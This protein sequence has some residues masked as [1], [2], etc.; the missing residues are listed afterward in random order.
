MWVLG[1]ELK[2][3]PSV[4]IWTNQKPNSHDSRLSRDVFYM[5]VSVLLVSHT[6]VRHRI[7]R[8]TF[9]ELFSTVCLRKFEG[10]TKFIG[11]FENCDF[12]AKKW[13]LGVRHQ[14]ETRVES[15]LAKPTH[16][17][18]NSIG[19]SIVSN[20]NR[21][22]T[23]SSRL[24]HMPP[25]RIWN[26]ELDRWFAAPTMCSPTSKTFVTWQKLAPRKLLLVGVGESNTDY[27]FHFS[28][29]NITMKKETNKRFYRLFYWWVIINK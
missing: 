20:W 4:L 14:Q 12:N 15:L 26:F 27:Y 19:F 29:P 8:G 23:F 16:V 11:I 22:L 3:F 10:Q 18:T 13:S 5:R 28:S 17:C 7:Y 6:R 24:R 2:T 25:C 1:F 9:T 21:L